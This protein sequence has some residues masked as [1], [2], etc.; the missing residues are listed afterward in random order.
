LRLPNGE[1]WRLAAEGAA[2]LIEE[3]LFLANFRGPRRTVKISLRG[4]FRD[5]AN[6]NW[7]LV[8]IGN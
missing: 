3:S 7:R 4:L 6:V 2:L 5:E 8:K 1:T